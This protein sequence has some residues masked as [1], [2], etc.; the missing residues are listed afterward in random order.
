MWLLSRTGL[1]GRS[2]VPDIKDNSGGQI[3]G[4]VSNFLPD[5]H[6]TFVEK[7]TDKF[8]K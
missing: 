4:L 7:N 3:T 2:K 1:I 6:L 8:S 5:E